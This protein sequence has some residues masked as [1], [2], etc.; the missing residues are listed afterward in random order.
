[1]QSHGLLLGTLLASILV[2]SGTAA[3]DKK[4]KPAK[5]EL[6][7][8][9][10]KEVAPEQQPPKADFSFSLSKP[11]VAGSKQSKKLRL[12][13]TLSTSDAALIKWVSKPG[14]AESLRRALGVRLDKNDKS[15]ERRWNLADC[16]PSR[17]EPGDYSPSSTTKVAEITVEIGHVEFAHVFGD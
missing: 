6:H 8:E 13:G 3:G 12:H 2:V 7:C 9:D 4:M 15:P 5:V 17:Y 14:K 10:G 11:K 1:M 16:F